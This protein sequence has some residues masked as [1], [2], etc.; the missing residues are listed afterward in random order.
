M[1]VK[2][3][4][5]RTKRVLRELRTSELAKA[6]Q[7]HLNDLPPA[8]LTR[9]NY[10]MG[11]SGWGRDLRLEL[12]P[13]PYSDMERRVEPDLQGLLVEI[14]GKIYRYNKP[15]LSSQG[16]PYVFRAGYFRSQPMHTW[17][18][19]GWATPACGK[20]IE[21]LP[22]RLGWAPRMVQ[23][24]TNTRLHSS[25]KKRGIGGAVYRLLVEFASS[26][27]A[28]LTWDRCKGWGTTSRPA[29]RVWKRLR[30]DYASVG[31]LVW[32]PSKMVRVETQNDPP[33]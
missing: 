3:T 23:V 12:A 7:G 29:Q 17:D 16:F 2:L 18:W 27:G 24:A 6:I 33:P 15:V 13:V 8:R 20:S 4:H 21:L 10:P 26:Q 22:E 31:P 19:E 28:P 25:L 32:D 5:A 1:P 30:R 11:M 9:A 14:T